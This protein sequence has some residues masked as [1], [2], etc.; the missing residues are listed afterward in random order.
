MS[1]ALAEKKLLADIVDGTDIFV[2]V[3]DLDFNWLAIN[4]ASS[5]EFARIFG[6]RAP[7]AG[8]NML[9]M[10]E[11]QPEH[12]LA[13][14]AV[15]ARALGGEEFVEVAPFGDSARRRRYYEMRFRTL[16]DGEGR[17]VGAYQFVSDVTERLQQQTRLKEAEAAL[18]QAQK[19]EAV[20]QLTGGIAHDFNNLLGAVVGS[21]DLIRRRPGEV[22]RVKRYA[23]AGLQAAERGAKLTA[24]LLAFSR[25]QRIETRPVVVSELVREMRDL[26]D[27]TL[28][29]LV[30]LVIDLHADGTVLSDPTQLEMAILNLAINARDAMPDGGNLTV[31]TRPV[32]IENDLELEPGDYIELSVIDTGIGMTA[33]VAARAFDPFFTTKDV[34]K[35]TGLGLSQVYGIARQAGGTARIESRPGVGTTVRICLRKTHAVAVERN[36]EEKSAA[37]PMRSAI[38]LVIDDDPDLRR[39]LT[40]SVEAL[41]YAVVEAADGPSGLALFDRVAPDLIVVDFAMPDMNGAEVAR[42]ARERRPDL[43]IVFASG[44]A[45]TEKIQR[46]AGDATVLRKPF[47]LSELQT[48]LAE[49][50][51]RPPA[52]V[53]NASG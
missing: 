39:V 12:Q 18:A 23:E 1:E 36:D 33:D 9:A 14:K 10:L 48:V 45:D 31:R 16:R 24:Q 52:R 30:K 35:G 11:E 34:G 51:H 6:V 3:A 49:A 42:A 40:A 27:R 38:V 41:G 2:Q 13:V 25:A 37:Q 29:P 7:Q 20:G 22:E 47:G 28:G 46:V 26:L 53:A 50:L 4:K 17:P 5:A 21:F 19:M 8:D 15:W 44:Y 43:P 32:H